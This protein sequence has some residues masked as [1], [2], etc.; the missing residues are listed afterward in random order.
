[1]SAYKQARAPP[2]GTRTAQL[3]LIL[4]HPPSQN[5][6]ISAANP[7]LNSSCSILAGQEPQAHL[8]PQPE[9]HGPAKKHRAVLGGT[10]PA[11]TQSGE[12]HRSWARLARRVLS[13]AQ[14]SRAYRLLLKT[15]GN[16]ENLQQH[17]Y[18]ESL[19]VCACFCTASLTF[20]L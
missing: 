20:I 9:R 3:Q 17:L 15:S 4:F 11:A 16:I 10:S 14:L 19:L 12:G 6:P 2:P 8:D 7:P 13:P 5:T 18:F 1:M